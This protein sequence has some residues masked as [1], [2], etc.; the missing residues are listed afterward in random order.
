M[1]FIV[2]IDYKDFIFHDRLEALD[3]AETAFNNSAKP[4]IVSVKLKE[5]E[6]ED[7]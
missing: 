7:E 5:E 4:T 6:A 2:S 3:F 1:T